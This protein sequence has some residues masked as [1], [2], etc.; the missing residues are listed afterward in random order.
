MSNEPSYKNRKVITIG[1]VSELTGLTERKIRYYEERK[2]IFPERSAKGNRKYSFSDV[3]QLIE[4]ANKR[5]EGVQTFEIRQQMLRDKR[6]EAERE[7]RQQM[8][9]GQINAR[10]GIQRE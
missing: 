4:I 6:K 2:L 7:S 9:R 5:E 3:E 10:F 8:L 1:I